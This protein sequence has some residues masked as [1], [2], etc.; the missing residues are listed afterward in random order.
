[1]GVSATDN[2]RARAHEERRDS[3]RAAHR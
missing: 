3:A 2:T 1:V